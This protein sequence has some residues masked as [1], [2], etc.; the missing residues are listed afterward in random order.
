MTILKRTLSLAVGAAIMVASGVALASDAPV[1]G[2]IR[3]VLGVNS[4]GGDTYQNASIIANRLAEKIDANIRVDAIGAVNAFRTLQRQGKSGNTIMFIHDQAYLGRLYEVPGYIDIFEETIV[5]PTIS[6]N[7]GNAYL[8]PKS[9]PYATVDDIIEAVG[10]GE[11]VRLATERGGASHLGYSALKN[12]I[13]LKYPGKEEGLVLLNTGSQA[14]KNQ[15][16]FDGQADV[17]HGSIQ[18]NEQFTRLPADDQKAMR[19]VW[20]TASG[21]TIQQMPPEGMGETTRDH[22]MAWVDPETE[23][24]ANEKDLFTYDKMFY[25]LYHKDM[26]PKIVKYF[27]DAIA[28]VFAEGEIQ[29]EFQRSFFIP[30]FRKSDEARTF[31]E[32]KKDAY[33]N[34][35]AGLEK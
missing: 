34:I 15:A 11:R 28:E 29:K 2:N 5:G 21:E 33:A 18:G 26:D 22:M 10:K 35:L 31:L 14:D 6:I 20:I 30:S 16:L 9:S 3:V 27:D 25:F 13:K 17:I 1:K 23:V 19:F 7:P 12:A 8:V 24:Y 4:T 32:D